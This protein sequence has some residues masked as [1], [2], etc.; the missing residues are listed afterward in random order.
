MTEEDYR[1]ILH[2]LLNG[3]SESVKSRVELD[4]VMSLIYAVIDILHLPRFTGGVL[5]TKH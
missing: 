1:S 5:V 3:R 4:C 2:Y